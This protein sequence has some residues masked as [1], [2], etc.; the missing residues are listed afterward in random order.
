MLSLVPIAHE[1]SSFGAN[2]RYALRLCR[3]PDL[4]AAQTGVKAQ[5]RSRSRKLVPL[6]GGGQ[7]RPTGAGHDPKI[8]SGDTDPMRIIRL[9]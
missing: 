4:L 6:N 3:E 7:D 9:H 5:K 2:A 8:R 1:T